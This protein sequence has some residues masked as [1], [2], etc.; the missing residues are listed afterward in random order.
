MWQALS[1][2]D[3]VKIAADAGYNT[4]DTTIMQ[5]RNGYTFVNFDFE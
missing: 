3:L 4:K 2:E 1:D 5:Q